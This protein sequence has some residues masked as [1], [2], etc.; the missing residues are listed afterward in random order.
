MKWQ[1]NQEITEEK[2]NEVINKIDI[3]SVINRLCKYAKTTKESIF[4]YVTMEDF[5]RI[6]A[7]LIINRGLENDVD[8]LLNEIHNAITDPKGLANADEAAKIIAMYCSNPNAKIVI[9]ADYDADGIT[10]G[11][12]LTSALR[13][14]AKCTVNV[15]YPERHE[16]YG[17]SM[18]FCE[19]LVEQETDDITGTV[20]GEILVITVDNGI[21]QVEEINY[22]KENGIEVIVTDHHMSKEVVPNCLIVDP[23]NSHVKQDNTYKHL[24]GCGVAFKVAQLVHWQFGN[25]EKMKDYTPY[26]AIST[27]ADVMPM[28]FEN[29]ALIQ[30]GL[31]IIN[32]DKCPIGL[33]ELKSQLGLD[34]ITP[35][36]ILWTIAPI[37]NACGRLGDTDLGS[38]LFFVTDSDPVPDII[39]K[40]IDMNEKRKTVTKKAMK[41]L[42]KMN[43]DND[44]ICVIQMADYPA[45]IHGILAGRATDIF[46]KP[47]IVVGVPNKRGIV[48]GSARSAQGVNLQQVLNT[49][50]ALG[51]VINF[52]G[53]KE[54]AGVAFYI[55]DLQDLRNSFNEMIQYAEVETDVVIEE[56]VLLIDEI[57][58]YEHINKVIYGLSNIIPFDNRTYRNP[59]FALTDVEVL[60]YDVS[61]NNSDNLKLEMKQGKKKFTIWA[62]GLAEKYKELGFPQYINLAGSINPLNKNRFT[63]NSYS[64]NIIDIMAS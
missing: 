39:A 61:K 52:G 18:D 8:V 49:Q 12:V 59:I 27:L 48:H 23:H 6:L 14:V 4:T 57:L 62:W 58:T 42:K 28:H 41:D 1:T 44:K 37:I 22:L 30:Y 33:K 10:A 60:S 54:A 34:L 21:T 29:M 20:L 25:G 7:T 31:D 13:D 9:F 46:G 5:N 53:H 63:Y 64:F 19:S 15:R 11:Y 51:N 47:S 45:G 32:S 38:K 16:G 40:I 17:L 43:F 55:D 36:D 24:C 35:N 2:I 50:V 56:P 3:D 26:L